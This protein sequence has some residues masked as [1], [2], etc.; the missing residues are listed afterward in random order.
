MSSL[1]LWTSW[2]ARRCLRRSKPSSVRAASRYTSTATTAYSRW[3]CTT[4]QRPTS[5]LP[6]HWPTVSPL[7]ELS[8]YVLCPLPCSR[9]T[10]Q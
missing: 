6:K 9:V 8:W 3:A 5:T 1:K 2:I 4:R 10:R 7:V